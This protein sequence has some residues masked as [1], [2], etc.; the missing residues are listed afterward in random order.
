[1]FNARSI[2][3]KTAY[4]NSFIQQNKYNLIFIVET[5]LNKLLDNFDSLVCPH[6]YNIIRKDRHN[7][8]GGGVL[9]IYKSTLRIIDVTNNQNNL[10]LEHIC[11]DVIFSSQKRKTSL[12]RFCCCYIPPDL[13]KDDSFILLFCNILKKYIENHPIF[14]LGDFIFPGIDWSLYSSSCKSDKVFLDFC[15]QNNLYQH[16][17]EQ[18][19]TSGST[20]DLLFTNDLAHGLLDSV[21]VL[22]SLSSTCDHNIIMASIFVVNHDS[23]T[24]INT[25][26]PCYKRGNYKKICEALHNISWDY[27]CAISHYNVQEIYDKFLHI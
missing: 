8:K 9:L 1:M 15:L 13:S 4:L 26:Y 5:W 17:F 12:Y 7:K 10:F 19:H 6:G 14:I 21:R 2:V 24:T 20:L 27:I 18:T 25:A 11:V 23:L 16:V 3:N 22:P